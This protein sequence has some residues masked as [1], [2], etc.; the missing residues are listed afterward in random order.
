MTKV[1]EMCGRDEAFIREITNTFA[2]SIQ[3]TIQKIRESLEQ[4][5]AESISYWSHRIKSNLNLFG[6][7]ELEVKARTIEEWSADLVDL[8]K[9]CFRFIE[10]LSELEEEIRADLSL[11]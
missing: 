1:E 3:E 5:N 4:E 8:K 9:F 7:Q 6:C 10:D 2:E 11:E